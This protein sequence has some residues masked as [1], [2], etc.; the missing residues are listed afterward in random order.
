[1]NA[2]KLSYPLVASSLRARESCVN[3]DSIMLTTREVFI[4]MEKALEGREAVM[5]FTEQ[6]IEAIRST[7]NN[8]LT[9]CYT[10]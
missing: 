2:A 4:Q 5:A 8:R 7:A 1:L 9:E 10:P 3:L 6:Q